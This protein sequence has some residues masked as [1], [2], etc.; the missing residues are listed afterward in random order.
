MPVSAFSLPHL[1]GCPPIVPGRTWGEPTGGTALTLENCQHQGKRF[2]LVDLK[3]RESTSAAGVRALAG[4]LAHQIDGPLNVAGPRESE[5]AGTY[6]AAREFLVG[7]FACVLA[8]VAT[9]SP[10]AGG[11]R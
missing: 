7:V 6:D 1:P 2:L 4:H 5:R 3:D 8:C 11:G 10:P 9:A